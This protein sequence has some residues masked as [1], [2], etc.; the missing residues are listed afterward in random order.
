MRQTR[1]AGERLFVD[2]AGTTLEMVYGLSGEVIPAQLFVPA[3]G[4]SSYIHA[5]ETLTQGL[6]DWIGSHTR[7]FAF[8]GGL[9]RVWYMP[10]T[11]PDASPPDY[12]R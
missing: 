2:Y 10:T 12:S 5:E 4:A 8:V 1:V 7:A 11:Q 6:A 9:N 3:L